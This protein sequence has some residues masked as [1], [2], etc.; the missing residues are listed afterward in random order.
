MTIEQM[1]A[2]MQRAAAKQLQQNTKK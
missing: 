2:R 1:L